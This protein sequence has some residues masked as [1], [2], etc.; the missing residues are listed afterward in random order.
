MME[1]IITPALAAHMQSKK[2]RNICVE[3]AQSNASDFE[4]TEIFLRLVSD[5]FADY[6]CKKKRYRMVEAGQFH[7]LLPPYKLEIDDVVTFDIKKYWIFTKLI[8]KGIRL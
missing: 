2:K 6:L 7:V 5:S 1:V 4:V 3:V 8:C